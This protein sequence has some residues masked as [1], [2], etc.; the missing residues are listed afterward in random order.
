MDS[1]KRNLGVYAKYSKDSEIILN[2]NR[3]PHRIHK[4]KIPQIT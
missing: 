4:N 2:K 1:G 3:T